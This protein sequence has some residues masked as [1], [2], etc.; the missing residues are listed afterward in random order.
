VFAL[1]WLSKIMIRLTLPLQAPNK[2]PDPG[3]G[4]T[5]VV[6]SVSVGQE[7]FGLVVL[8]LLS[9]VLLPSVLIFRSRWFAIG[10]ALVFGGG[11]GNSIENL[12]FGGVT[13]W[14]NTPPAIM[15]LG[16]ISFYVGFG[17]MLV[18][19]FVELFT[20]GFNGDGAASGSSPRTS[21][22]QHH[23][24]TR[25]TLDSLFGES[26]SRRFYREPN[27]KEIKDK[28][29]PPGLESG[30]VYLRVAKVAGVFVALF[31]IASIIGYEF[32]LLASGIGLIAIFV[33]YRLQIIISAIKSIFKNIVKAILRI[34]PAIRSFKR[35]Y[36]EI[37]GE[38]EEPDERLWELDH[39]VSGASEESLRSALQRHLVIK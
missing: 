28:V 34:A 31:V 17:L 13:N 15:N 27:K 7:A 29:N 24:E 14:I 21:P 9:A 3:W 37:E 25:S 32:G 35:P 26:R 22:R 5:H 10:A 12:T 8:L 39:W 20:T 30:G 2:M 4:I 36:L 38:L 16:D 18:S 19:V 6:H 23:I 33:L 1:D 11:W